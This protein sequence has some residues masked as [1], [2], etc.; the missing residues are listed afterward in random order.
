MARVERAG[1]R[2]RQI[3]FL[4]YLFSVQFNLQR[5]EFGS[6]Y[7]VLPPL[8]S[9]ISDEAKKKKEKTE[10]SKKRGKMFSKREGKGMMK[11]RRKTRKRHR[12]DEQKRYLFFARY[13]CAG[14][15]PKYVT[16][17]ENTQALT[18]TVST[19]PSFF[20]ISSTRPSTLTHLLI[21]HANPN[22]TPRRTIYPS[23]NSISNIL[24]CCYI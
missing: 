1:R 10:T 6:C 5:S 14:A 23:Y 20:E 3:F 24:Y 13:K 8:N 19:R 12:K 7:K 15:T 11:S 17:T 18:P 21:H 4:L 22:L 16:G 2:I 9:L